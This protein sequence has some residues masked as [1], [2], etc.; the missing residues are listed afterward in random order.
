[1]DLWGRSWETADADLLSPLYAQH[2]E[3]RSHPFR[4]PQ[5]PLEYARWAYADQDGAAEV[6][7]GDALISGDRAVIEWWA[8]LVERGSP[9]SLA[10]ASVIRFDSDGLV[11]EQHDYWCSTPGRTQPWR[12]WSARV[13][14][15][16]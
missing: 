10:G 12:T 13:I 3:F 14:G 4:D 15:S 6:W 2:A 7:F 1:M 16:D 11:I 5:P 9:V 8:A